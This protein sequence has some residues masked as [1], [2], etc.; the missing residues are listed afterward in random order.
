MENGLMEDNISRDRN[1]PSMKVKNL[2]TFHIK[3]IA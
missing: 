2:V 1:L 3:R